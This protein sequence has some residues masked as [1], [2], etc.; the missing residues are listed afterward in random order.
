M[1]PVAM[2]QVLLGY[3]VDQCS[4]LIHNYDAYQFRTWTLRSLT[5][6]LMS[7]SRNILV[8]MLRYSDDSL[9][10]K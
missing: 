5:V 1:L 9:K 2:T 8:A 4:I 3:Q 7:M 10:L 6:A